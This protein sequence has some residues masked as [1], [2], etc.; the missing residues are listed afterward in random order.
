M[1]NS[2]WECTINKGDK[3]HLKL[4]YNLETDSEQVP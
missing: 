2:A 1:S 4:K 3:L